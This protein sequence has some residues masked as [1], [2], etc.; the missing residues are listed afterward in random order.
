MS[1]V[2]CA[3]QEPGHEASVCMAVSVGGM[4]CRWDGV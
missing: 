1:G 3:H 2:A 4:V